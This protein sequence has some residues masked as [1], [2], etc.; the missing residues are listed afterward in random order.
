MKKILMIFSFLMAI[1]AKAQVQKTTGPVKKA[2]GPRHLHVRMLAKSYSDSIVVRWAPMDA[3]AWSMGNDSGYRITRLD[4]TDRQHPVA[5]VLSAKLRPLS[6]EQMMATLRHDD[7]YAAIAAQALYGKDFQM[8]REAPVGFAKRIKQAHDALSFRYSFA[9]QAADFS[10]EVASAIALR[11]VDKDVKK[12][13][14]YIYV[15]T[16]CGATKDYV[17]DSAATL[18]ADNPRAPVPAP[19]GLQG[20]GFDRKAELHWNRR[21]LG[22]FS[23]YEIERSDDGGKNWVPMSKLPYFSP[24]QM[25]PASGAIKGKSDTLIHQISALIRDH[26]VFVDSLPQDYRAYL[27]RVRGINA[28]AE[29]S[30]WCEPVTVEGRDLTPPVAPMIDSV[31]NTSGSVLRVNWSQRVSNPD[32]AGYYISKGTSVK[33]PFYPLTNRMLPKETRSFTDSAGIPHLPNYYVIV[34]VDTAKNTAVSAAFPGYLTDTIPPA[35]PIAVAGSID[36]SG[37]VHLHWTANREPDLKGYK[38][39]FAYGAG[40]QFEEVGKDVLTDTTFMDSVS[41]R[42]LN[43]RIWYTVVAVDNSNNHSAY[44]K[45]AVLHKVKVVPPSAPVAGAV[46]VAAGLVKIEWIESRSDGAAGYE[47]ARLRGEKEFVPAG[48]LGQ[49]W[50]KRSVFFSDTISNNHDYYYA[51]R[52]I[53][54]S[55]VKSEWSAPVHVVYHLTDSLPTAALQVRLDDK[56]RHVRLSWQY[57]DRGDYFFVVYRA[58][59]HGAMS[60]WQS[61]DKTV[62]SGEDDEAI[63]GSYAYAIKVVHRD[64]S[65]VSALSKPIPITI[66]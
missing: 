45:P 63:S 44:S 16:V 49:D 46:V 34:A 41:T 35:A 31:R 48:R 59:G 52:T 25:P 40:D 56:R 58:S 9:L 27:Y 26:Q 11:W 54:S 42:S 33:G 15:I 20:F 10:P 17:V 61:F 2:T 28:F 66:P 19:D 62:S 65:A 6:L 29:R 36:S 24:D 7:P 23:A 47:L 60:A 53:D 3:V 39:Y 22:N 12:G 43:R 18:V 4:Y 64:G 51:A 1:G 55:G 32:L 21:Q 57:K 13:V 38:V 30:P 5:T 37:L 8:T 14:T 50:S